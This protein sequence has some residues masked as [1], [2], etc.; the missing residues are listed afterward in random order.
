MNEHSFI[1]ISVMPV[2]ARVTADGA[3][4]YAEAP[5][6]QADHSPE[7]VCQICWIPLDTFSLKSPCPGPKVPDDIAGI[8]DTLQEG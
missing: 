6:R 5:E 3:V 2:D 1:S 7:Q 4:E 8:I